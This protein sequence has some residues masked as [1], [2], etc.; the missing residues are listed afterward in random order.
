[1][2]KLGNISGKEAVE[3]VHQSWL[4]YRWSSGEPLGNEQAGQSG[5]SLYPAA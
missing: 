2:A 1:M 4:E 5:Q 3:G